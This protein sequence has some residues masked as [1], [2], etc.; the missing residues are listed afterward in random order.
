MSSPSP[1]HWLIVVVIVLLVFGPPNFGGGSGWPQG[2]V[3]LRKRWGRPR[4]P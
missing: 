3:A 4:D 1:I 2:L